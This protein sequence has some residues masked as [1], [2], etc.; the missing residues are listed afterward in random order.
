MA[1]LRKTFPGAGP[2][3]WRGPLSTS[4]G[5]AGPVG[6]SAVGR[7]RVGEPGALQIV[8]EGQFATVN[9]TGGVPGPWRSLSVTA[10]TARETKTAGSRDGWEWGAARPG[11]CL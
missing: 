6:C 2:R 5:T 4:L 8:R 11:G 3:R 9:Q 1:L 7:G 10:A